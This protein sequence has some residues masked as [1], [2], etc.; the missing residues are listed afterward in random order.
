MI[1][2]ITLI[3]VAFATL[4]G[5]AI[6]A[7][8]KL[9]VRVLE[10]LPATT[11]AMLIGVFLLGS[12][13][14]GFRWAF[15]LRSA[16]LDIRWR[17]G[18]TSYLAAMSTSPLPGGSWLA[19]RLAQEHGP[20]RMRQ[21]AP[22]LFVGFVIDAIT[23]PTLVLILFILTDQPGYS[24]VVPFVGITIGL[25]LVAMAR[26]PKVWSIV[27]RLLERNRFTRR[28]LPEERDIQSRVQALTR[29]RVLLGG[30][31]FSIGATVFSAL[32]LL[33]LVQALTFR[34]ITFGESLWVHSVTETA[35]IAIPIPGGFGVTDSS[36]TGLLTQYNIGLRRAT[37]LALVL[38]S[39]STGF[40]VLFGSL[41]LFVR[42]DQFL[43]NALS[44]RRRTRGAYRRAISVPGI[45]HT[46][47]PM[48]DYTRSLLPQPA[49]ATA[50]DPG[51]IILPAIDAPIPD[52]VSG[53]D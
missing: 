39:S 1:T 7:D 34:G 19:P 35:G 28:W 52:E 10:A 37:F 46:I 18:L 6:L 41:V 4:V 48:V 15:Y 22:A 24:F 29:P 50:P 53:G 23:V 5:L 33:V 49:A 36:M 21:A 8:V 32:F 44:I 42:Y 9:L 13:L 25:V 31:A 38:R 26:S 30:I 43:L 2:R 27:A 11:L 16:H 20:V 17:D 47:K 14:K 40:R 51:S 45:K 12:V 3:L